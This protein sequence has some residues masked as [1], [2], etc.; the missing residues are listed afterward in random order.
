[1]KRE[2]GSILP[3]SRVLNVVRAFSLAIKGLWIGIT[4]REALES[5]FVS[6]KVIT[7]SQGGNLLKIIVFIKEVPDIRIPLARD[8]RSG[9]LRKDWNVSVLNPS[10]SAAI[11]TAL[12]IKESLPGTHIT[13]IHLGP[14]SGE[15]FIREGLALGCD[16]GLRIWE[17]GID[18]IQ[19]QGKALIFER[20]ARILGFDII[21][22][23]ARSED[24]GN[25]QVGLLL[26]CNLQV[27][28]ITPVI[29]VEIRA[30]E[31]TI[32][33][34]KGLA[35]GY[36]ERVE[37]PIPLVVAME[38]QAEPNRYASLPT[39]L[40]ATEKEIPC[41][42]LA[43]IGVSAQAIQ[44]A[45]GHFTL[46][47]LQFPRSK[48]KPIAPPDSCLPAFDRIKQLIEGTV[49]RREGKVVSGTEDHVVDELFGTLLKE[50]W[51]N[52]LRKND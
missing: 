28:C 34:V 32:V 13:L 49:K 16:D 8:E 12:V 50:G 9:N 2:P 51:L 46:G 18:A 31:R 48:L 15:R 19:A 35:Q 43:R 7:V 29:S 36:R 39:L 27:P 42:D 5:A 23:G 45:N 41:F 6:P 38:T 40:E 22:T 10:D 25:G 37:S 4:L 21:L 3:T 52:H 14:P 20:I 33:A 17:E 44:R 11:D 47:Q 24:T 1:M 26:A 30:K